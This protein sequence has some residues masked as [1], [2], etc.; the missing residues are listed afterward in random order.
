H[1]REIMREAGLGDPAIFETPHYTASVN[2][3]V[4][5]SQLYEARYEQVEY[6]AGMISDGNFDP[7]YSYGQIF[8]YTVH[9]IMVPPC[10]RRICRIRPKKNKTTTRR[11]L[12][13]RLLTGPKQI[14]PSPSQPPASISTRFSTWN[15]WKK[16]SKVYKI[17]AMNS[18]L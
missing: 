8:P 9:D 10:I 3:Y 6:Y 5:M 14:L 12:H 7:E 16:L 1:G 4:A 17:S 2:A 18:C 11:V 15:T 13:R